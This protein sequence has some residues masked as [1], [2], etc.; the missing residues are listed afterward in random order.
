MLPVSLLDWRRGSCWH[1]D[2]DCHYNL[3]GSAN[4]GPAKAFAQFAVMRNALASEG[5]RNA[6]VLHAM[7]MRRLAALRW[8]EVNQKYLAAQEAA[9]DVASGLGGT[10]KV[11]RAILQ[12]SVRLLAPISSYIK[13]RR[14]ASSSRA[15]F[16]RRVHWRRSKWQLPTG[17]ALS[18]PGNLLTGWTSC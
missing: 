5:R 15:Q 16:S 9:S 10:S 13:N 4:Q 2:P 3:D 17:R 1:S 7:G 18:A 12:S 14:R 6:E 8:R 11:F